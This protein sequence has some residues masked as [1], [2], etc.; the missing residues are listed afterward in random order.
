MICGN[1][2]ELERKDIGHEIQPNQEHR[3][4]HGVDEIS[5]VGMELEDKTMDKIVYL[6]HTCDKVEVVCKG[7]GDPKDTHDIIGVVIRKGSKVFYF[8]ECPVPTKIVD[9]DNH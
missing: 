5:G 8:G 4:V 7:S 6:Q 9:M 2:N 3:E 1:E